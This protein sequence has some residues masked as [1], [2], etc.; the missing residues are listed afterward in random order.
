DIDKKLNSEMRVIF[1]DTER[2]LSEKAQSL[3][4]S[5]NTTQTSIQ[6]KQTESTAQ[7]TQQIEQHTRKILSAQSKQ[8]EQF[9][10]DQQ[11]KLAQLNSLSTEIANHSK[12]RDTIFQSNIVLISIACIALILAIAMSV[13]SYVKYAQVKERRQLLSQLD[14]A[15]QEKQEELVGIYTKI[16]NIEQKRK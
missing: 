4:T 14:T 12:I 11:A 7:I 10:A 13:I 6:A 3:M 2:T 8:L 5:I 9:T 16:Y 15:I 1:N